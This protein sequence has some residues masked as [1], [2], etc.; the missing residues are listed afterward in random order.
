ME[1][2]SFMVSKELKV[3]E[4]HEYVTGLLDGFIPFCGPL[5]MLAF[6][7]ITN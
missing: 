5:F 7:F 2:T 3:Y 4:G 1:K 6:W